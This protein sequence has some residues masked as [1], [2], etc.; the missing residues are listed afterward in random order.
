MLVRILVDMWLVFPLHCNL[1]VREDTPLRLFRRFERWP[2]D[3]SFCA[4]RGSAS[5][6]RGGTNHRL[7]RKAKMNDG[8]TR[9][10]S[11]SNSKNIAFYIRLFYMAFVRFMRTDLSVEGNSFLLMRATKVFAEPQ[12]DDEAESPAEQQ[13]TMLM[14][15][16][17]KRTSKTFRA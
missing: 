13:D 7:K 16:N 2:L 8:R 4:R 5:C 11:S 6:S 3:C 10:R 9:R 15:D 1:Q 12:A 14:T 17:F